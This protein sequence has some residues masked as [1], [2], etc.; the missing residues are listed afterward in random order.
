MAN[1]YALIPA[2]GG[3]K[4]IPGKNRKPL[5]GSSPVQ[6]AIQ[7]CKDAGIRC[8]VSSEDDVILGQ[9]SDSCYAGT[10]R[11]P[12]YLSRDDTPMIE[13]VK[14]ALN[15]PVA[16]MDDIWLLVQPTQP[17]REAKHLHAAIELLAKSRADS[18]VSVME[19]PLTHHPLMQ[20]GISTL[21]PGGAPVLSRW[22]SDHATLPGRRQELRPTYI[23]D[24]TVYAFRRR[25]VVKYGHIYG[26]AIRALV[27]PASETCPL[28]TME[29]W[30]D[31]ERKLK[32]RQVNTFVAQSRAIWSD[33]E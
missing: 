4:G 25:T 16:I 22:Y 18:V 1:T 32:Q 29:D 8:W 15:V 23:R 11:R 26:K 3:S 14:H 5:A 7:C 17:L 20:F 31:A 19:L 27:I 30:N 2:R 21:T 33:R 9:A 6:R 28:D 24:G 12:K 10:I 13:V